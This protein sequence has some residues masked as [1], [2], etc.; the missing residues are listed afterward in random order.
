MN[1]NFFPRPQK[2]LF[3]NETVALREPIR[4][5]PSDQEAE[6]A[7]RWL[8]G[9][10]TKQY[11]I[12]AS[13]AHRFDAHKEAD[14][15]FMGTPGNTRLQQICSTHQIPPAQVAEEGCRLRVM[16]NKQLTKGRLFS[17]LTANDR[18]GMIYGGHTFLRAIV[19]ERGKLRLPACEIVD[20]PTT[21]IRPIVI[22]VGWGQI[23]EGPSRW[24]LDRWFT[25]LDLLSEYRY[26]LLYLLNWMSDLVFPYDWLEIRHYRWIREYG[27][28]PV[29]ELERWNGKRFVK[30]KWQHPFLKDPRIIK[31]IVRYAR[32][33]GIRLG[34][35]AD[36][37]FFCCHTEEAWLRYWKHVLTFLIEEYQFDAF[38]FEDEETCEPRDHLTACPVCRKRWGKMPLARVKFEAHKHNKLMD[39]IRELKPDALVSA[40]SHWSLDRWSMYDPLTYKPEAKTW[41]DDKQLYLKALNE[42]KKTAPKEL[43]FSWSPRDPKQKE[44]FIEVFGSDRIIQYGYNWYWP[45]ISEEKEITQAAIANTLWRNDPI[46]TSEKLAADLLYGRGAEYPRLMKKAIYHLRPEGYPQALR[47]LRLFEDLDNP[48]R[49]AEMRDLFAKDKAKLRSLLNNVRRVLRKTQRLEQQMAK[50]I[51]RIH[52]ALISSWNPKENAIRILQVFRKSVL[53]LEYLLSYGEVLSTERRPAKSR[54]AKIVQLERLGKQICDCMSGY[55]PDW[56]GTGGR[57][58]NKYGGRYTALQGNP[59]I[60]DGYLKYALQ[61]RKDFDKAK[62]GTRR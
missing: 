32:S 51:Q 16:S 37:K 33:L 2:V 31:E 3:G 49:L 22:S 40:V 35:F 12:K 8:A 1:P 57:I 13:V 27:V 42:F 29:L 19:K 20:Y 45:T 59:F 54:R 36:P 62:T 25:F 44:L 39:I 15:L 41:A 26:N 38:A 7:A 28:L 56:P 48:A 10:I 30:E 52:S 6:F 21:K 4:I 23:F 60:Y 17:V 53:S 34:F 58:E 5:I 14:V 46:R 55:L 43:R 9:R 61:L 24:S 11:G 18:N 50:A 47:N